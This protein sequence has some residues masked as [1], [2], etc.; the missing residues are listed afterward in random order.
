MKMPHGTTSVHVRPRSIRWIIERVPAK[1]VSSREC[2]GANTPLFDV[3][4]AH[5]TGPLALRA[6]EPAQ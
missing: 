4:A 3:L 6:R 2:G 1:E 5:A